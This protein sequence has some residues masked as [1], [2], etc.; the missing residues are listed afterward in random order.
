MSKRIQAY[1]R[2]ESDAEGAKTSL[3]SYNVEGLEVWPLD[4]RLSNGSSNRNFLFPL[5]PYN[6]AATAAGTGGA[7]TGTYAGTGAGAGALP[8]IAVPEALD[9][10]E[11]RFDEDGLE[12]T[13]ELADGDL[14]DLHYVMELKVSSENYLDVIKTLRHKHAFVEVFD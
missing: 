4:D 8:G 6:S 9:D 14:D 7:T 3:I 5:I 1:F 11:R 10:T 12:K 2:T 13:A